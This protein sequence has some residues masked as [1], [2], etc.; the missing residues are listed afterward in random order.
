MGFDLQQLYDDIGARIKDARNKASLNQDA[1]GEFLGLTRASI[2]NIENGRQRPSIHL[3]L[4]M[5][6][7]L[8]VA[9]NELVPNV[10]ET[11][12]DANVHLV[13]VKKKDIQTDSKINDA[14]QQSLNNFITSIQ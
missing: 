13:S 3:L 7:V 9:F 11:S 6:Q 12:T 8:D 4:K 14:G 10:Q 1:L 2:V 5:A